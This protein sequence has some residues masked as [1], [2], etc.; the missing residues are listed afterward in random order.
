[1]LLS[2]QVLSELFWKT[3]DVPHLQ[4]AFVKRLHDLLITHS[5][6]DCKIN[7]ALPNA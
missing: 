4:E 7:K 3:K 2:S 1:M 6:S 5:L